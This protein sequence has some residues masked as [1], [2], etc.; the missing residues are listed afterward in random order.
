M[1]AGAPDLAVPR[2]AVAG[3]DV[4]AVELGVVGH[5]VPG[6]PAAA[7]LPP[8]AGPGLR[9][10]LH[11]GV[12][13]AVGRVAGHDPEAPGL[14]AALGVVGGDIAAVGAELAAGIADDDLAVEDAR[15]AGD[16]QLVVRRDCLRAP[17]L[18]A[19]LCIDGEQPAV[20]GADVDLALPVAD[21]ARPPGDAQLAA[22]VLRDLGV[23]AP[24]QSAARGL[25]GVHDALPD[26]EV[27]DAVDRERYRRTIRD[28][29]QVQRPRQPESR[30]IGGADPGERA[31]VA[32]AVRAA[33]GRPVRAIALVGDE[34][35]RPSDRSRLGERRADGDG[36]ERG[37]A[38]G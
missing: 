19:A 8:L 34:Q 36:R 9:R 24:Q 6:L 20:G 32:L 33:E 5:G 35:A 38:G 2:P 11:R 22:G 16:G 27:D 26:G 31:R 21:A 29:R 17:D 28:A 25:H 14:L 15:R 23:V 37:E 4:D 13:E 12:L 7:E 3:A 30:H 18:A 10:H 1:S